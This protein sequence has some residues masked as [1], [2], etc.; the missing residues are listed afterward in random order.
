MQGCQ[1]Y[2]TGWHLEEE[3]IVNPGEWANKGRGDG[4]DFDA[5]LVWVSEIFA[6]ETSGT[7]YLFLPES[8]KP[9]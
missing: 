1:T 3:H 2:H 5:F 4:D 6:E 9:R 8:T 7:P